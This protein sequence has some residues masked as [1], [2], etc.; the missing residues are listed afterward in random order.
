MIAVNVAASIL[1]AGECKEIAEA[2]TAAI[3]SVGG[4]GRLDRSS[5]LEAAAE[6]ST[7]VLSVGCNQITAATVAVTVLKSCEMVPSK[8]SDNSA[9][10]PNSCGSQCTTPKSH[11][12]SKCSTP[13]T[14]GNINKNKFLPSLTEN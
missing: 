2:A 7:A 12:G 13:R 4:S 6:A 14:S 1:E 8:S 10:I 9:L 3:L 5:A 11:G